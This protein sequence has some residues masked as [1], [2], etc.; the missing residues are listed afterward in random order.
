M[1]FTAAKKVDIRMYLGYGVTYQQFNT[2]LEGAISIAESDAAVEAKI[3]TV[4]DEIA[5][6]EAAVL[7][8][9]ENAGLKRVDVI[10][11]YPDGQQLK[12]QMNQGRVKINKLSI[13]LGVK[14]FSDYFGSQGYSGIS[15]AYSP[16]GYIQLG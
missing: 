15:H 10:E 13:L 9:L 7:D 6:V 4:L 8:S 3:L 14:P 5:V 11:F 2:Y 1:A 12:Y 16:Y